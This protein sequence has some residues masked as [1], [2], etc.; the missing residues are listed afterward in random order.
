M[1]PAHNESKYLPQTI[2]QLKDSIQQVGV[3]A[4]IIVVDDDSSDDTDLIAQELGCEVVKVELRNIGAVRNAGAA[5]AKNGWLIFVDADTLVPP[6]TLRETLNA[7]A[8][9][10]VGGGALVG[11]DDAEKLSFVKYLLFLAVSVG[12]Q[13]IG[14]WAAGCYVFANRD[15]FEKFGGFPEAYFAGEEFFVSRELKAA[16]QFHLCAA[17]VITSTRKLHD[18]STWQLM[19]FLWRPMFSRKGFLKSR[20]GLELLYEHER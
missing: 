5:Q 15:A 18:Y 16:G 1:I 12:W 6:E 17:Q 4:E 8:D 3:D 14:R 20:E 19:R 9:G 13:R 2:R 7:I 11:I 10:C